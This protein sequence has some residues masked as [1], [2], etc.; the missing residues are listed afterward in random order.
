MIVYSSRMS[1]VVVFGRSET[2]RFANNPE[3]PSFLKFVYW[4]Q[5]FSQLEFHGLILS[6]AERNNIENENYLLVIAKRP[7]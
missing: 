5:L 1:I 2:F 6:G 3:D 4:I 7:P